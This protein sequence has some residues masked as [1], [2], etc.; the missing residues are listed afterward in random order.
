MPG[1]AT[2][3]ES[4]VVKDKIP[5]EL[6]VGAMWFTDG[7]PPPPYNPIPPVGTVTVEN[8]GLAIGC[9]KGKTRSVTEITWAIDQL[10]LGNYVLH[11]Y[12]HTKGN[13]AGKKPGF[14]S[15]GDYLINYG[16]TMTYYYMG[17]KYTIGPTPEEWITV[18]GVDD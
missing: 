16:A 7:Q 11:F 3:I 12:V 18:V 14:T 6:V 2:T 15:P 9:G 13:P 17:T 5:A 8:V 1:S 10:G 4:I